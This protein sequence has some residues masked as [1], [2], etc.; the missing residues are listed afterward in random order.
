MK[1]TRLASASLLL[2]TLIVV[3]GCAWG[4]ATQLAQYRSDNQTLAEQCQAQLAEIENL[5]VHNR[6]TEDRLIQAEEELALL[7]EDVGLD[8]QQ[9]V[10][11][12]RERAELHEQFRGLANGRGY[13]NAQLSAQLAELSQQHPSLKFD[14]QTGISKLDTDVLFDSGEAELKPGA[15]KMLAD[16]ARVL[17]SATARDLKIMIVGHTDNQRI[18]GQATWEKFPNNFHLSAARALAVAD[19]LRREGLAEQRIGVAG[20]G[21]H[22]PIAPNVSP[23]DRQKNRRVEIFILAPDVPVVGLTE[24]IPSVY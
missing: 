22:Q 21:P 7:E 4:P 23:T 20:F 1:A 24:S 3:S 17:N 15:E 5:K 11:Y 8:R 9:L 10:D 14:P 13:V 2:G 19:Q 16:L 18:G 12:Q 6:N